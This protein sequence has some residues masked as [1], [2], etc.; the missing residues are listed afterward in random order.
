MSD[1]GSVGRRQNR[2]LTHLKLILDLP[3]CLV[4]CQKVGT[5]LISNET[6]VLQ[7]CK[8]KALPK[9]KVFVIAHVEDMMGVQ[10]LEGLLAAADPGQAL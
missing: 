9:L 8:G 4:C 6:A 7:V 1:V 10:C 3:T 5:V 2:H